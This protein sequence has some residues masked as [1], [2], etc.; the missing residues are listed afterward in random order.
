MGP[1][2]WDPLTPCARLPSPRPMGWARALGLG[3][4][5]SRV[6]PRAR[7]YTD[8]GGSHEVL[9]CF[10]G[11]SHFLLVRQLSQSNLRGTPEGLRT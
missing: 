5:G 9:M 3:P 11:P 7:S 8:P 4:V 10:P 1:L 6:R 2:A